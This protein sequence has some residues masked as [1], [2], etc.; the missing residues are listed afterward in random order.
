MQ[1][2]DCH[3]TNLVETSTD[4]TCRECGLEQGLGNFVAD[5]DFMQEVDELIAFDSHAHSMGMGMALTNIQTAL[6]LPDDIAFT[7]NELF[8]A[9][10]N[11]QKIKGLYR[12]NEMFVACCYF[13][14]RQTHGAAGSN[15]SFDNIILQTSQFGVT[16]IAWACSLLEK[17]L[18][19]IQQFKELFL[20]VPKVHSYSQ[21]LQ[22]TNMNKYIANIKLASTLNN[23][24]VQSIRSAI[25]K[26]IDRIDKK[27]GIQVNIKPD[28]FIAG[29]IFMSISY[30]KIPV[31][32]GIVAKCCG[33][34]ETTV[35]K[36][37]KWLK[38]NLF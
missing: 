37:E 8:I 1:C 36:S 29:I 20:L 12:R 14:S 2:K 35:L 17:H 28:K 5:Y 24:Q 22:Q 15:R 30:C 11:I 10:N 26:I 21:I 27:K 25:F 6:H 19:K 18:S 9:F 16:H 34:T 4:L 13:A 3:S 38:V 23:T 33:T 31:K 7:A 32:M